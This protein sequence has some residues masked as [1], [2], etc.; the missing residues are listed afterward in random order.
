MEPFSVRSGR[1]AEVMRVVARVHDPELD[2]PV[3]DMGF[4]ERV[5]VAD[6]GSVALDF[7]LP[8][9]WCSPNFAFLMLD[10]VREALESLSWRPRFEIALHDHLFAEEV[11]K[12]VAAGKPFAEIFEALSPEGD[13]AGLRE[14]FLRKAFQKRQEAALVGLREAGW[15][16]DDILTLDRGTLD[17]AN[18]GPELTVRLTHYL[19]ALKARFP[20]SGDEAAAF[21]AWEGTPLTA[22]E[23]PDYLGRLR[24][25]RINMEFNGALCRGLKEARYRE[26]RA[27]RSE[28]TLIDFLPADRDRGEPSSG[29][30]HH[31][32]SEDGGDSAL[33]RREGRREAAG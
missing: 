7:R 16:D 29:A 1:I 18:V 17:K 30:S 33:P 28:L 6:D 31:L 26:K 25:V 19:D 9:Y 20:S 11:N 12:G 21:V 22:A 24:A 5:E 2:E 27:D 4:V 32:A 23:L 8:T 14:T 10:G 3:T 15:A 13:L